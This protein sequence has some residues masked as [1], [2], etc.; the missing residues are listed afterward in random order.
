M[1]ELALDHCFWNA[2]STPNSPLLIWVLSKTRFSGRTLRLVTDELW[3]QRWYRD[4]DTKQES[5]TDILLILQDSQTKERLALHIE[6]K[7][8]HGK[9]RPKQA[10]SYRKR[11]ETQKGPWNY[12]DFQTALVAPAAFITQHK[13]EAARFDIQLAYEEVAK[14]VPEFNITDGA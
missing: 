1:N 6:N 7:P 11:A 13:S 8:P 2:I 10:E 3:H 5:E 12:S 14:F 9:W 4:P